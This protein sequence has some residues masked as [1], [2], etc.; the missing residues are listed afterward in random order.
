MTSRRAAFAAAI[1]AAMLAP[2]QAAEHVVKMLNRGPSGPMVFEPPVIKIAAGDSVRFA[3]TDPGHNI[4]TIKG[5]APEGAPYIK[6][7]ISKDETVTF[8]KEGV[9]GFKCAPHYIM[10]MVS[11]VVVGSKLDNL[12]QARAVDH[13]KL[14]KKRVDGYLAQVA[15]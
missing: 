7:P 3:A 10:G 1:L 13:G 9:Y 14:A 8:D 2:A 5:M 11:I 4:E 6:S 12:E 15:P